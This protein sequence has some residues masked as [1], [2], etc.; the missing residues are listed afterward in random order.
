[1][2][3]NDRLQRHI[4]EV[5]WWLGYW[6]CG[7]GVTADNDRANA[8]EGKQDRCGSHDLNQVFVSTKMEVR[9]NLTDCH[10]NQA[11]MTP[12]RSFRS[13]FVTKRHL[14]VAAS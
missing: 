3:D 12:L 4:L 8:E 9:E 5:G 13:P 14:A 7:K 11:K 6:N 10:Q 1:L 2:A